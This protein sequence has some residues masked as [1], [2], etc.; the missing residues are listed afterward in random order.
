MTQEHEN[1]F[2]GIGADLVQGIQAA[3]H[4]YTHRCVH[5]Q[6]EKLLLEKRSKLSLR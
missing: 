4:P 5:L 2:K 1:Q 6:T 3:T